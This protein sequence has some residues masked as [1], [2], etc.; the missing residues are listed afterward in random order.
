MDLSTLKFDDKYY[1]WVHWSC[2][3]RLDNM[4]RGLPGNEHDDRGIDETI[5][6]RGMGLEAVRLY[7]YLQCA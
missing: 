1:Y 5:F 2:L 7:C 6:R 3:Q 4:T